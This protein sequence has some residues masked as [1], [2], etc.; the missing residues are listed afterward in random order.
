MERTPEHILSVP[1][2][3]SSGPPG[4]KPGG[5]LGARPLSVGTSSAGAGHVAAARD[6]PAKGGGKAHRSLATRGGVTLAA[7]RASAV[8]PSS[9]ELCLLYT[10]PSPRD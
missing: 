3:Q 2:A 7:Q 1:N 4:V 5:A 9:S 10:S 6:S 8:R